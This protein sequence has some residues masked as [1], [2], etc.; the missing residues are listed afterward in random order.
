MCPLRSV[1]DRSHTSE[2]WHGGVPSK[3]P[4]SLVLFH[5]GSHGSG[6]VIARG[7]RCIFRTQQNVM[8]RFPHTPRC[9]RLG[10]PCCC[11]K[12]LRTILRRPHQ[13]HCPRPARMLDW[14]GYVYF[15]TGNREQGTHPCR[16]VLKHTPHDC[17]ARETRNIAARR[18]WLVA[19]GRYVHS[20]ETTATE[21][22]RKHSW[23]T[24]K[25][26]MA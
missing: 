20:E 15:W 2:F 25:G 13:Q 12:N 19:R 1:K 8:I 26:V 4:T 5:L 11:A 17:C 22:G 24:G 23:F 16:L 9:R 18:L 21:G 7:V 10:T 14:G 3:H 6:S